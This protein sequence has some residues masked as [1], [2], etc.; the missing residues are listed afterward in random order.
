MLFQPRRYRLTLRKQ[1]LSA[2]CQPLFFFVFFSDKEK[3]GVHRKWWPAQEKDFRG[4]K[5][6]LTNSPVLAYPD[7]SVAS[8]QFILDT[9]SSSGSGIGDVLSQKQADGTEGV[10]AYRSRALHRHERNYCATRLKMLAL[11]ILLNTS[12]IIC[13][14]EN[15]L[16][17]RTTM[18]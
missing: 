8:G 2:T 13:W 17:G 3:R 18:P 7:F 9:D 5:D 1:Q 4:L 12:V 16:C 10:T 11:L 6:C 15:F 14:D